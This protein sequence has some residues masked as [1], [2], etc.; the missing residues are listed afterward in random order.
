MKTLVCRDES[1]MD[2]LSFLGP[3]Q[4]SSAADGVQSPVVSNHLES[5]AENQWRHARDWLRSF[6]LGF[7]PASK[8]PIAQC[9]GCLLKG[10]PSSDGDVSRYAKGST[11]RVAP[12]A[13]DFSAAVAEVLRQ[14][15]LLFGLARTSA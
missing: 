15:Y 5:L 13:Y 1:G 9:K 4:L 12:H 2:A 7:C 10:K 3:D 14:I 11:N 8:L 6:A